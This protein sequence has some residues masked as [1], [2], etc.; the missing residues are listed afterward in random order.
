MVAC[1]VVII[2]SLSPGKA[3]LAPVERLEQA[4]HLPSAIENEE[5][6]KQENGK[7]KD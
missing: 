2:S 6:W 4:I 3:G 5:M 1:F 7:F